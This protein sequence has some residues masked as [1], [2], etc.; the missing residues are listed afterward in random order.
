MSKCRLS[1]ICLTVLCFA[2]AAAQGQLHPKPPRQLE[3]RCYKALFRG[4]NPAQSQGS[5]LMLLNRDAKAGDFAAGTARDVT[6]NVVLALLDKAVIEES[7]IELNMTVSLY[8]PADENYASLQVVLEKNGDDLYTGRFVTEYLGKTL[9]GRAEA[10]VLP[11]PVDRP[12]NFRLPA[13]GK[14]PRILFTAQ[15]LPELRRRARTPWG[16]KAVAQL[17]G[18]IGLAIKYQLTGEKKHAKAVIPMVREMIKRGLMSDQYGH[19]VGW[20]LEQTAIA[21]DCCYDAWPEEFRQEV[22]KYMLWAANGVLRADQT[23]GGGINWHVCSNWS[24]PLYAGAGFA[25]MALFGQTGPDPEKPRTTLS[26]Q[27]VQPAEDY[28]PP[29]GVPTSKFASDQM[30]TDWIYVGPFDIYGQPDPLAGLGG[31]ALRLAPEQSIPHASARRVVR[32]LS[33]EKDKGYYSSRGTLSIDLTNAVGR[34]FYTTSYYYHVIENDKPRWVQIRTD[35]APATVYLNGK[36]FVDGEVARLQKGRI[37]VLIAAEIGWMNSW[38]RHLMRPRLADVSAEQAAEIQQ[39][40]QQRHEKAMRFHRALEK[41]QERL[42]GQSPAYWNLLT[43]SRYMMYRFCRDAVGTGGASA[44][45]THYSAIAERHPARYAGLHRRLFG[46]SVSPQQ[47]MELLLVR[48]I[49]A[50]WYPKDGD[51]VAQEINGSP[52]ADSDLFAALL[53]VVPEEYR[54]AALWAWYRHADAEPGNA[55]ALMDGY[56][57]LALLHFPTDLQPKAPQ[58]VLPLTWKAPDFGLFGFRSGY[59]DG[60]EEFII[61]T[62]GK[63][64]YIGGWNAPNAGTFRVMG[65]GRAWTSAPTDRNRHR[66]EESVVMLPE[67]PEIN[68]GAGA[69]VTH[70]KMYE[71]GSG[72]VS[73]NMNDVYAARKL[74]PDGR[75]AGRLYER[76]GDIR[77]PEAF[78]D[79]GITGMRSIAV[80]Y[81]KL[82]GADCLIAIVD[83]I[84][85]GK[86]KTWLWQLPRGDAVGQIQVEGNR[87]VWKRGQASMHGLFATGQK[88]AA[89]TMMTHMR[90]HAGSSAGKKLDRPIHVISAEDADGRFFFVATI[91]SGQAPRMQ[92]KGKG[93]DAVITIGKRIVRFDGKKIIL[94]STD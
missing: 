4:E 10:R 53:P 27:T 20:R 47:D 33:H 12:E 18:P 37:P 41:M 79:S 86:S 29:A 89:Q 23:A 58:G 15:Q 93:L 78:A 64:H 94:D 16:Q 32:Q 6:T 57:P 2:H 71:D 68:D 19:N 17:S 80:D 65:L 83:R 1:L 31:K 66:W 92:V 82:S 70:V 42:D 8:Y 43:R 75:R 30:P 7:R 26:G 73:Y 40:N 39:R 81:S 54:E 46:Y 59:A 69:E 28:D 14:H 36:G 90:G 67:N 56:P 49:F 91:Q 34:T 61:Q 88:P 13:A 25:G 60:Q 84:D 9:R 76:Y 85:G 62:F 45:L 52:K 11:E 50:H 38:G 72:V 44:E 87:L 3:L 5:L 74:R 51:P 35:Y 63:S 22:E 24:S 55:S 77:N 48:K 21:Y